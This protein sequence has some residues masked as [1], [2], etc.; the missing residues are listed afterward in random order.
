MSSRRSA[1]HPAR[2]RMRVAA[3]FAIV[4]TLAL[5]LGGCVSIPR[6][7]GVNRAAVVPNQDGGSF[8]D[9]PQGPPTGVS[10]TEL[11]SDFMQA[12]NS[13]ERDYAVA[14]QYLT[15]TAAR[16][17]DPTQSVLIREGA[18]TPELQADGTVQ[19]TVSTKAGVDSNGIYAEYPES[20]QVLAF[21]F[22]KVAGQ[23]R[24]SQ[25]HNGTIISRASF[26]QVF[27]A[28]PL[29]FFDPTFAALVPDVR[30]FPT[31]S[32]VQTRIASALLAGPA[33]WLQQGA[34]VSAF[35]QGT[36]LN[37]VEVRG[38]TATVNLSDNVQNVARK[39]QQRMEAQ[40]QQS[41]G[42]TTVTTVT[43][44]A[45]GAPLPVTAGSAAAP[46]IASNSAALVLRGT[47]FGFLP[48]VA[49]I[50][51]LSA[52][53][54]SVDARAV[55]ISH[56]SMTG[57]ALG[58]AGVYSL[59]ATASAAVLADARPGLIAPSIDSLS[60]VWSVPA[61]DAAAIRVRGKDGVAHSVSSSIPRGSRI[62]SLAISSDGARALLYLKTDAGPKLEVAGVLRHNGT[63]YALGTPLDLA[64]SSDTPVG[65][66]WVDSTT[67]ATLEQGGGGQTVTSFQ[68]GGPSASLGSPPTSTT[69]VGGGQLADLRILTKSGQV[70]QYRD[71]GWQNLGF[72]VAV[73]AT[74]Q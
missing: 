13:P 68:I 43:M 39:V 34:V 22:Q 31:V 50:P 11:I 47:H 16:T 23:W 74:Q 67:V 45:A 24:I 37:G 61:S 3:L 66:T 8:A 64:A 60:F 10:Q 65:A 12:T 48:T 35:P 51:R 18:A 49:S 44:T 36:Q 5:V 69:I 32:T 56:D 30:W 4:T 38:T 58:K 63:P 14:K 28:H 29:Y 57:A 17:W 25:L 40:L 73:L 70:Q 7:G 59:S 1:E 72:Q 19:Y 2:R 15:K 26:G 27:A 54:V 71:S 62:V 52:Q 6:A 46:A 33:S 21:S 55:T 9:L 42:S 20:S 53:A 41:L